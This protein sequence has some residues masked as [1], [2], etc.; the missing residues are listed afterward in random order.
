MTRK[1]VKLTQITDEHTQD[2][3]EQKRRN[4]GRK[5]TH[6]EQQVVWTRED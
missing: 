4:V 5:F 2:Y 1:E 6:L 3:S